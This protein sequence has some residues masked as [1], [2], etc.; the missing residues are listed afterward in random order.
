MKHTVKIGRF[1]CWNNRNS[2]KPAPDDIVSV[3]DGHGIVS[4]FIVVN[5]TDGRCADCDMPFM[6]NGND[7]SDRLCSR[8]PIKCPVDVIFKSLDTILEHI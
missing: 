6:G 5:T 4:S 3:D 7:A 1:G 2:V 8:I